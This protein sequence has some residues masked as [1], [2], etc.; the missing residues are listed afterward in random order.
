MPERPVPV[1]RVD[2]LGV[3]FHV[4]PKR[5]GSFKEHVLES[6]LR[7]RRSEERWALR[8][9]SF[10]VEPGEVFGVFGPNGAGK[11]TLLRTLARTLRPTEGRVRV[12]G[13]VAPLLALGSGFHPDMSG[14][15]N[16]LLNATLLGRTDSQARALVPQIVDFA[17]LEESMHMPIRQLSDGMVARLGF[18][19]ATAIRPDLLLV[20]EILAVGDAAFQ[21]KCLDRIERFRQE[22][23]AI[24]L[25]SHQR[26]AVDWCSRG[27][28]LEKGRAVG[29]GAP[30]VLRE[31][32]DGCFGP[33]PG[34]RGP[35][36]PEVTEP[37]LQE[38]ESDAL[39]VLLEGAGSERSAAVAVRLFT[40]VRE[41]AWRHGFGRR[42]VHQ[43]GPGCLPATLACFAVTG[44]IEATSD[45]AVPEQPLDR[46]ALER[47]VDLLR[48]AG[49]SGWWRRDLDFGS[50]LPV[51]APEAFPDG[52]PEE[53]WEAVE[54]ARPL[55]EV[56]PDLIFSFGSLAHV[57]DP[58]RELD[59]M[60]RA[61]S[62]G[63]GMIHEIGL[64]HLGFEDPLAT[65]ELDR[66][67]AREERANRKSDFR[68][69]EVP[70]GVEPRDAYCNRWLASD[71]R[72]GLERAG[73][74][75]LACDPLVLL[76]PPA[77]RPE[78]LAPEFRD[79][80]LEDLRTLAVRVVAR[81]R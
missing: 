17:E 58:E 13:T 25:V 11:S 57:A 32:F 19:V 1:V 16:V 3:C 54:I 12:R 41:Q 33:P 55:D 28:F 75:V 78:R 15:E 29:Q 20:D 62:P 18:A 38:R 39:R 76:D 8:G 6:A 50:T 67:A 47:I 14:H 80:D 37:E 30:G 61:L 21:Q 69:R 4:D 45:G 66:E 56:R 10:R 74:E 49:G 46:R 73:F 26:R 42:R 9:V 24:V 44:T 43:V 22:G 63:G 64:F 79:R 65:L 71:W 48:I 77:V 72:S 59:R 53:W 23:T 31:R 60:A 52:S 51:T 35:S 2:D 81:R 36:A 27:L 68:F 40:E 7:G 34:T 70:P 5:I